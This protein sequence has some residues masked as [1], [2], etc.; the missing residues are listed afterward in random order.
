[1]IM[2]KRIAW[3]DIMKYIC[4]MFIMFSHTDF[5]TANMYRLYSPFYLFGFF[6][7]SGYVY[8]NKD[9]FLVFLKKK[10]ISILI[11][12][13]LFG[14]FQ[15]FT[16][17]IL[18]FSNHS[19]LGAELLHFF[20]QIRGLDDKMWFLAALYLAFIP[21]Y[22]SIKKY[23]QEETLHISYSTRKLLIVCL[24]LYMLSKLYS[25]YMVASLLPWNKVELP[26]HI[27]YVFVAMFW[28]VLGYLFKKKFEKVY[29]ERVTSSFIILLST[30]YLCVIFLVMTSSNKAMSNSVVQIV[31]DL[32]TSGCSIFILVF[33]CKHIRNNRY[34]SYIGQNTLICFGIHGKFY[35]VMQTLMKKIIIN[36]YSQILN[37]EVYSIIV[38]V[39][40]TLALSILLIVP[41]YIK[42]RWIPV[43]AGK[44]IT[45]SSH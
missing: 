3:V 22:F 24:V 30:I 11:P 45:K 4:I 23:E 21:F 14:L 12:W 41:I 28:M 10:T 9:T 37:N 35:S 26:W 36:L 20:A 40:F 27:E 8:T 2:N 44:G 31:L 18:S 19:E 34:I 43:L 39:L 25:K 5:N 17:H 16:S 38:G 33:L 13:F 7:A 42:N 32:M 1:M 15:I 6:F 29:D